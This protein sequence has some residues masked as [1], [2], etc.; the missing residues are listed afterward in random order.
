M[1]ARSGGGEYVV[2]CVQCSDTG[3]AVACD[4]CGEAFCEPCFAMLHLKG[5]RKQHKRRPVPSCFDCGFQVGTPLDSSFASFIY[6]RSFR[7][8]VIS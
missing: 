1:N 4:E 6:I 7:D 5:N 3:A 2:L 8:F